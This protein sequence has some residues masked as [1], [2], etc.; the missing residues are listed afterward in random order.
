MTSSAATNPAQRQFPC[1]QCGANLQYAPGTRTLVCPYC[2]TGN[3]IPQTDQPIE[4]LDFNAYI[5]NLHA[6]EPTH[7]ILTVKCNSCGAESSLPPDVVAQNCPFCGSPIV[8]EASSKKLIK[9]RSLLPFRITREQAR[10]AFRQWIR[11]LWFAPNRL[12]KNA[13]ADNKLSGIYMPSWTYDS[14]TDSS[15][16]G[17]R[18]DDYWDTE[19]Y[20]AIE[21]GKP[22]TRTRQVRKTRWYPVSGRV[23]NRFDDVL[24]L[25]SRSLPQKYAEALEP[26]DLRSLVP[27][28]DE[29]LSGFV[30]ESYQVDLAQGFERARQ[31][32]DVTIRQSVCRDIGGDH[33]RIVS[34]STHYS[35]I[36]FKHLLLPVWLSAYRYHEQVYHFL[37]NART[38]EVQGERPYSW[39]KITLLVLLIALVGLAIFFIV[40]YYHIH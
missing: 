15:Y 28:S 8:A 31:I 26:W 5:S 34:L 36:T 4:E 40:Q 39:I 22:V 6:A 24:V 9:P 20:T 21:N 29:Y 7:E 17:M 12:K 11:G 2:G 30:C 1:K 10:D 37:V 25:A 33:Q 32:M 35:N 23:G 38:G 13:E 14:D 19:T 27:Y 16:T 18:G 3:A